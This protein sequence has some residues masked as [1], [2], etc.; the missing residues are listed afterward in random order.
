MSKQYAFVVQSLSHVWFFVTPWT[1]LCQASLPFTISQSLLKLM[2]LES[3]TPF[4]HLIV[5]CHLLLS[6]QSFPT[7]GSFLMS[8]FFRSGGQSIGA[9]A[10]ASVLLMNIQDLF[11]VGLTGWISLQ[12]EGLSRAFSNTRVQKY[13]FYSAQPSLWSNFHIHT[14]LPENHS[15]DYTDICWK[16]ATK[17]QMAHWKNQ[18]WI[19]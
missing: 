16:N 19:C 5:C 12:P 4:N 13:Q 17:Q 18:S 6:L 8:Q 1:G 14:W 2:S 7:S 3:V 11:P 15:F 9:S 10:T